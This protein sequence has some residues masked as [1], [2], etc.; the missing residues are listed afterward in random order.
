MLETLIEDFPNNGHASELAIVREELAALDQANAPPKTEPSPNS[1]TEPA[2]PKTDPQKR[3][4]RNCRSCVS[5]RA[6]ERR[7]AI[8]VR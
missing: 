7:G 5:T 8:E 4:P 1:S 3:R 6:R 2:I